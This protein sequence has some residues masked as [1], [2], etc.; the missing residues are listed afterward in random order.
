MECNPACYFPSGSFA[1]TDHARASQGTTLL[2]SFSRKRRSHSVHQAHGLKLLSPV[3]DALP[4]PQCPATQ[5]TPSAAP[6]GSAP[7]YDNDGNIMKPTA[8]AASLSAD[9]SA[10]A[11]GAPFPQSSTP[12]SVSHGLR[13]VYSSYRVVFVLD[14]GPSIATVCPITGRM[15]F[16]G[17]WDALR[18][19]LHHLLQSLTPLHVGEVSH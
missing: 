5:G 9:S 17:L 10:T 18:A 3:T 13:F 19:C 8:P 7:V 12:L 14:A 6:C 4:S 11:T 15:L 16:T 1:C 2:L